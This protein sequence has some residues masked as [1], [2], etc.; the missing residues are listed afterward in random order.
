MSGAHKVASVDSSQQAINHCLKN[1]ELNNIDSSKHEAV[2]ADAFKF[3]E[4]CQQRFDII[5]VDPPAFAK[6]KKDINSALKAY[7]QVNSLAV[8]LLN[9]NGLF[10]ACSCSNFVGQQEFE[11][12][13]FEA[14]RSAGK[15]CSLLGRH[16][17]ALDHPVLAAHEEGQYLK[18]VILKVL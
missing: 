14:V 16:R 4:S 13:V 15:V 5:I 6:G 10:I 18:S 1:I 3:L 8:K 9:P 7:Y 17:H 11:D 12:A 2:C